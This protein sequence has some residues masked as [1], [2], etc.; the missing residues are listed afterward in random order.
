MA[1]EAVKKAAAV[2]EKGHSVT[3]RQVVWVRPVMIEDKPKEIHIALYPEDNGEITYEIY[4]EAENDEDPVIHSQGE[5]V[6]TE[7]GSAQIDIESVKASCNLGIVTA[8]EC[9]GAFEKIGLDYGEAYRGVQQLLLGEDRL[10]ARIS[11]PAAV[12]DKKEQ[13]TLHPSMMDAA[14]HASV[15]L[16]VRSIHDDADSHELSL[17]FA[18]QEVEV[19]GPCPEHIWSYIRY[20]EGSKADDSVRKFDIDM[21]DDAGTVY[22]RMKGASVRALDTGQTAGGETSEAPVGHTMLIPAWEPVALEKAGEAAVDKQTAVFSGTDS[23][24]TRIKEH[25]PNASYYPIRSTDDIASLTH[26]LEG[27][28]ELEQIIWLAPQAES[29]DSLKEQERNVLHVFKLMKALLAL[30]YGENVWTGASSQQ[31]PSRFR[32][33]TAPTRHKPQSADLPEQWRKN[34]R[35]GI[36]A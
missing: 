33:K 16:L 21:C 3:L 32:I 15:G 8:E 5:A 14:F 19:Y 36:S 11:L 1:A 34:I 29:A 20:T 18:M 30:G 10:L 35:I 22:V 23:R 2:K 9:Y 12:H 4:S 7:Q 17:P 26:M 13:Y 27:Q 6:I 25:L 31:M 24:H 28:K